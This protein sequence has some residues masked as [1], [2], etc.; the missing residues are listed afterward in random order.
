MV[1]CR[2]VVAQGDSPD[3]P[4][5]GYRPRLVTLRTVTHSSAGLSFKVPLFFVIIQTLVWEITVCGVHRSCDWASWLKHLHSTSQS[6]IAA[7]AGVQRA[8]YPSGRF[9]TAAWNRVSPQCLFS[10]CKDIDYSRSLQGKCP[11]ASN[12]KS[13]VC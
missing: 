5:S 1:S 12:P 6:G 10:G 13:L 9:A 4:V 3:C 7:S 11:A 2:R 8:V